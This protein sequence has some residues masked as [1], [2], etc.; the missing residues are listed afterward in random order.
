MQPFH[1][2]DDTDA[3]REVGRVTRT[4]HSNGMDEPVVKRIYA[5]RLDGRAP[6]GDPAE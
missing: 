5:K 2:C 3:S 1:R 4:N 6:R